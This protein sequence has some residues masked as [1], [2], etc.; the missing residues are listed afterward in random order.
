MK[1]HKPLTQNPG[2]LA[3][4][5]ILVIAHVLGFRHVLS[6]ARLSTAVI[7]GLAVLIVIKHLGLLGPVLALFRRRSRN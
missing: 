3:G 7:A 2:L 4:L 6:H 1:E 5:G